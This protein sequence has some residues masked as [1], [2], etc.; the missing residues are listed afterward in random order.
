MALFKSI[1]V[2]AAE[3]IGKVVEPDWIT[4]WT[5][6]GDEP[7]QGIFTFLSVF[8]SLATI[9]AGIY[10]IIQLILAGYMYMSANGDPKKIDI[11]G[12]KIWQSMVGLVIVAGAV[13]LASVI[14]RLVGIQSLFEF[15]FLP[16]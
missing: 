4:K 3:G 16:K 14:A 15:S 6:S 12:N 5:K 10:L 9:I 11:A 8:I 7:G 13:T 2:F 1:S